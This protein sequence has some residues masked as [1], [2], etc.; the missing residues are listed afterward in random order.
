METTSPQRMDEIVKAIMMGEFIGEN[1]VRNSLCTTDELKDSMRHILT[2]L[3]NDV[4]NDSQDPNL[5]LQMR[6]QHCFRQMHAMSTQGEAYSN[7]QAFAESFYEGHSAKTDDQEMT[8]MAN[9][10]Y[11]SIIA[12]R[13]ALSSLEIWASTLA[14]GSASL[15]Q[16]QEDMKKHGVCTKVGSKLLDILK[17][18]KYRLTRSSY[19]GGNEYM[20]GGLCE[21]VRI[22]GSGLGAHAWSRV[23]HPD[24]NIHDFYSLRDFVARETSLERAPDLHMLLRGDCVDGN[25]DKVV[26]WLGNSDHTVFPVVHVHRHSF[27]FTDGIYIGFMH[28]SPNAEDGPRYERLWQA[29]TDGEVRALNNYVTEG[30]NSRCKFQ[31]HFVENFGGRRIA[32]DIWL[33]HDKA[34]ALLPSSFSVTRYI[35]QPGE[36]AMRHADIVP[37]EWFEIETKCIDF[38]L[39]WQFG[40]PGVSENDRANRIRMATSNLGCPDIDKTYRDVSRVWWWIM[41]RTL[42][43]TDQYVSSNPKP[44]L[45]CKLDTAQIAPMMIGK[46]RCGKSQLGLTISELISPHE[47]GNLSNHSEPS[48][49]G[50]ALYDKRLILALECKRSM[51]FGP[52]DLQNMISGEIITVSRK[53]RDPWMGNWEAPIILAA[54]E[55]PAAW[56]DAQGQISDRLLIFNFD[57]GYVPP[58]GFTPPFTRDLHV[59]VHDSPE[60]AAMVRKLYC[61][62]LLNVDENGGRSNYFTDL[63]AGFNPDNVLKA[64]QDAF[65][66]CV[67]PKAFFS[68]RSKYRQDMDIMRTF[69]VNEK[70]VIMLDEESIIDKLMEKNMSQADAMHAVSMVGCIHDLAMSMHAKEFVS[71]FGGAAKVQVNPGIMIKAAENYGAGRVIK[72]ETSSAPSQIMNSKLPESGNPFKITQSTAQMSVRTFFRGMAIR[73]ALENIVAPYDSE[74]VEKKNALRSELS[75]TDSLVVQCAEVILEMHPLSSE[76]TG[77]TQQGVEESETMNYDDGQQSDNEHDSENEMSSS[78][79][80]DLCDRVSKR[81]CNGLAN[82]ASGGPPV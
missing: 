67:L 78:S 36:S 45:L 51:N 59:A 77:N 53:N 68:W 13:S 74:D 60:V 14:F 30:P 37:A 7:M 49:W 75:K 57:H 35:A 24:P 72:I 19:V 47:V 76:Q 25:A 3:F 34:R 50:Q 54:N 62:H 33:S 27:A 28:D 80:D 41:G 70:F 81:R 21:E 71:A 16:R 32:A 8:A 43:P 40:D 61:A 52:A 38:V 18:K 12:C 22:P 9:N 31:K 46:A 44:A 17:A 58:K 39:K 55:M 11:G 6:P 20:T 42:F 63:P 56:D 82:L 69:F 1:P 66:S 15:S 2:T 5:L 10:I 48:F 4:L 79:D 65:D 26:K 73:G 64:P 23:H 29:I